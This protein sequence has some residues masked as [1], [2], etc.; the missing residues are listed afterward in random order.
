[1][2]PNSEKKKFVINQ[3]GFTIIPHELFEIL[4]G[5]NI[6]LDCIRL[7]LIV[8]RF[9]VGYHLKSVYLN[10]AE[11]VALSQCDRHRIPR[12]I[13]WL[14]QFNILNGGP[15][16]LDAMKRVIAYELSVNLQFKTWDISFSSNNRTMLIEM[17]KRAKVIMANQGP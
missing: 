2:Q 7:I 3:E 8:Y 10:S 4:I 11:L 1:M 13:N 9:S 12:M 16:K 15:A 5:S 17:H 14:I 6:P